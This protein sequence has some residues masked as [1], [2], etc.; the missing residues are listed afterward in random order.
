M[1]GIAG[2][3][4]DHAAKHAVNI[5]GRLEYR[6]Y[7]SCGF[8]TI[9][10]GAI[11]V[12]KTEGI[13]KNIKGAVQKYSKSNIAISHTRWA[14]NGKPNKVNAHPHVVG[15]I[16]VVHNGIIENYEELAKENAFDLISETDSEVIAHLIDSSNGISLL[17]RV[18][19]ATSVLKGSYSIAVLSEDNPNEIVV[20]RKG[21]PLV[22]GIAEGDWEG[23]II[24]SDVQGLLEYT[25][26][27]YIFEDG[28]FAILTANSIRFFDAK[29]EIEKKSSDN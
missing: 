23:T 13:V 19:Q 28:E 27:A 8:A 14:T 10:D 3:I 18:R 17:E 22:A 21:S 5:L 11:V 15:K 16:A 26:K 24:S 4:G 25:N 2:Y 9:F 6:G 1:C 29:N 20:A 7:D 12:E